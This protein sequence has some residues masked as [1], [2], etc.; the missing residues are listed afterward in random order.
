MSSPRIAVDAGSDA[1]RPDAAGPTRSHRTRPD[2]PRSDPHA[3]PRPALRIVRHRRRWTGTVVAGATAATFVV[4]LATAAVHTTIV[5][6]QREIDQLDSR[7]EAGEQRNQ[8]LGLQVA[9]MEAPERIVEAATADGMVVPDEVIWLTPRPG[10]GADASV[11][12]R[13]TTPGPTDA[14]AAGQTEDNAPTSTAGD[15]VTDEGSGGGGD[16]AGAAEGT[17]G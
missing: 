6:G 12:A 7:I 17:A 5:S 9:Q 3:P 2:T 8:A 14:E 4:L 13:A 1:L 11:A 10:G 16:D 15:T